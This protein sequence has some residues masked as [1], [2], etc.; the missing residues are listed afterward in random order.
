MRKGVI[1]LLL[2]ALIIS[3]C[4]DFGGLFK[5]KKYQEQAETTTSVGEK[6]TMINIALVLD[7]SGSMKRTDPDRMMIYSALVFADMLP[8]HSNLYVGS[9]PGPS[10]VASETWSVSKIRST[11]SNWKTGEGDQ[12]ICDDVMQIKDWIRNLEYNSQ[13]TIF[14]EPIERA[15]AHLASI[16]EE[17]SRQFVV[18]FSDGI[19]D[20]GVPSPPS[21]PED[22][23][24]QEAMAL[25]KYMP[26]LAENRI[27]FY[28]VI[29][30]AGI[31]VA[32]L[33]PL[34]DA[35][36]GAV[37]R[38]ESPSDL[39]LKFASIFSS[40]LQSRVESI[41]LE[42]YTELSISKYVKEMILFVPEGKSLMT[43]SMNGPKG[44]S[45]HGN[46]SGEVGF[47]RRDG[48]PELGN[49][50][51]LHIY[52]PED[53]IWEAELEG[54]DI[55]E[56]L[57]VQNFDVY[58]NLDGKYPRKGLMGVPNLVRGRMVDSQGKKVVSPEF[59]SDGDFNYIVEYNG[60][61]ERFQP[62]ENFEFEMEVIPP[63]T[64]YRD[65]RVD[66]QNGTWLTRKIVRKMG[67][68][69]G[70]HLQARVVDF[71]QKTPYAD[72]LYFKGI[73]WLSKLMGLPESD[74]WRENKKTVSFRGSDPSLIGV[75]FKLD[76]V[77]LTENHKM[78]LVDYWH[79][80]RFVLDEN[81]MVDFYLDLDRDANPLDMGQIQIP[82]EK[83]SQKVKI[84]GDDQLSMRVEVADMK[85]WW[86]SSHLW[87]QWLMYLWVFLFFFVRPL[88]FQSTYSTTPWRCKVW[89]GKS[90]LPVSMRTVEGRMTA[91]AKGL[92]L[93]PM[94]LVVSDKSEKKNRPEPD[95]GFGGRFRRFLM[96]VTGFS[97]LGTFLR[98]VDIGTSDLDVSGYIRANKFYA[99]RSK[100][101]QRPQKGID[102]TAYV[103]VKRIKRN[104]L[105]LTIKR[106]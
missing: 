56:A 84:T 81:M 5:A 92:L 35:T 4:G 10:T 27:E 100:I 30:G 43:L 104:N 94:G 60:N 65:L 25:L 46:P 42:E 76:E 11:V 103:S 31:S 2:G 1:P 82:I 51:V 13:I 22:I 72:G 63:D 18:F 54:A 61:I 53:G 24:R 14:A 73:R 40:I 6:P 64:L 50:Q 57:L 83:P 33:T 96:Y 15:I 29:L 45:I 48:T 105:E 102:S 36:G 97:F 91:F 7:N 38:A 23:H 17:N 28:S 88:H 52:N 66:A 87:L 41:T 69:D 79:R 44:R 20:R 71:G 106:K 3:G 55:S 95:S 67:A 90:P 19:T 58:L 68:K 74:R 77:M 70:A 86:R 12:I 47:I 26:D 80:Q 101:E 8:E 93:F 62:N 59:F 9:F 98:K 75:V 99:Q 37:L 21:V 32:H 49:Y 39:S 78:L 85:W 34:A 89:R 16:R